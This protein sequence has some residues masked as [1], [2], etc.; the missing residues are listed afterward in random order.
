MFD[1][2]RFRTILKCY[3]SNGG[4]RTPLAWMRKAAKLIHY[5]ESTLHQYCYNFTKPPPSYAMILKLIAAKPK[6]LKQITNQIA[7]EQKTLREKELALIAACEYGHIQL[8]E[9]A[10]SLEEEAKNVHSRKVSRVQYA[11]LFSAINEKSSPKDLP[12][13]KK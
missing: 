3:C 9:F 11:R 7:Y 2:V 4:D 1:R 8:L 6:R 10:K 12:P 5:K 13:K